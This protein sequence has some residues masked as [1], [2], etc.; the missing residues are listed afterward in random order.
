MEGEGDKSET[1]IKIF[2]A[3]VLL[4]LLY[5]ARAWEENML[6]ALE[7]G[8]LRSFAGIRWDD[9]A[10]NADIKERLNQP[11]VSLKLRRV[12]LKWFVHVGRMADEM[13]VKII[14]NAT[15]K[16]RRPVGRSSTRW[17]DV[18]ARH[19]DYSG[20]SVE[21]MRLEARD[22]DQWRYIVL[23]SSDSNTTGI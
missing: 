7:M 23:A 10:C 3:I 14:M 21:E 15:M 16:G 2:N 6:D 22:R 12:K 9:F 5:G 18:L 1:E 8:M 19:L 13:Q 4:G 17:K 11:P 20:F